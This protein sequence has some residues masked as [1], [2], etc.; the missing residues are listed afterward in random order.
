[1][2]DRMTILE[3]FDYIDAAQARHTEFVNS[4]SHE[5]KVKYLI[6]V[7]DAEMGEI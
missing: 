3:L 2:E 1:M 5:D 7:E 6:M 4:L